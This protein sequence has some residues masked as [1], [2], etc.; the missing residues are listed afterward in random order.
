MK[1]ADTET[2]F[3]EN[4]HSC[5][6][7]PARHGSVTSGRVLVSDEVSFEGC[8][9]FSLAGNDSKE[10]PRLTTKN[11]HRSS[12]ERPQER[13]PLLSA[14]LSGK[15]SEVRQGRGDPI[16]SLQTDESL[17]KHLLGLLGKR[18]VCRCLPRQASYA[19][20]IIKENRNMHRDA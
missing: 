10:E 4:G 3:H 19:D 13:A 16:E 18:L 14:E 6:V 11:D 12:G 8:R 20:G 2:C 1:D 9:H 17:R 5:T 7:L 15:V